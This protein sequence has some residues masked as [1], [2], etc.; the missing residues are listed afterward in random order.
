VFSH[1][2][3]ATVERS[4]IRQTLLDG[5]GWSGRG[6]SIQNDTSTR[7]SL[8]VRSSVVD[9]SHEIGVFILG[10]DAFIEQSVLRETGVNAAGT[11]GRNLAV[12]HDEDGGLRGQAMVRTSVIERSHELGVMV[13]AS[14]ATFEQ[15]VVRDALPTP[16]GLD[17]WCLAAQDDPQGPWRGNLTFRSSVIDGCHDIGLYVCASDGVVDSAIVRNVVPDPAGEFGRGINIQDQETTIERAA[18][19]VRSSV[20]EHTH[21]LALFVSASDVDV[22][23][24][25]VRDTLP[26]PD[27]WAGRGINIQDE[28]LTAESAVVTITDSLFERNHDIGVFTKASEGTVVHSVVRDTAER[29]DGAS[30][31]GFVA[32]SMTEQPAVL[33]VTD[34]RI[35]NNHRAGLAGFGALISLTNVVLECNPIHLNGEQSYLLGGEP[36]SIPYEFEDLGGNQCGCGT[37]I[38]GCAVLTSGLTPPEAL[39]GSESQ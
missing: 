14:D 32:L 8:T 27:G 37:Q 4:V 35:A 39:A 18:V 17:G 13:Y 9:E 2:G 24:T 7:A 34:S 29:D 30:G 15:V 23:R 22:D 25:L 6:I 16:E 33:S 5:G 1:A 11:F 12:R 31:D 28:P 26:R 3:Q 38:E 19:L 21:E 20:V 36:V 10:S